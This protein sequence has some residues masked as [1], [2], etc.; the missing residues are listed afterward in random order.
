MR[1]IEWRGKDI[2]TGEWVYGFY[3]KKPR[4]KGQSDEHFIIKTSE[5]DYT[6]K[7]TLILFADYVVNPDT[8]GQF[9]GLHDKNDKEIYE[10]DIICFKKPVY[11]VDPCDDLLNIIDIETYKGLVCFM[12]GQFIVETEH[13]LKGRFKQPLYDHIY[14]C[15]GNG[16]ITVIGNIHDNPELLEEK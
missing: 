12:N 3:G 14:A 8:I 7:G 2:D 11:E 5:K 15:L 13:R 10:G 4:A 6:Q 1:P 16:E 9:T